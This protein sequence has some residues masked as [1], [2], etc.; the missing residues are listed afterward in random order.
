MR[1]A[2][3]CTSSFSARIVFF[4]FVLF[5]LDES[6]GIVFE[7]RIR[8]QKKKKRRSEWRW[9]TRLLLQ[10]QYE[11]LACCIMRQNPYRLPFFFAHLQRG[12]HRHRRLLQC[13]RVLLP[14]IRKQKCKYSWLDISKHECK[15]C[16]PLLR[17]MCL[18][19]I[20]HDRNQLN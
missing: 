10:Q 19:T 3:P 18:D 14:I 12:L 5:Y 1:R 6:D 13:V 8:A 2:A 7:Q 9:L 17:K 4:F 15:I 16:G 11:P 20:K